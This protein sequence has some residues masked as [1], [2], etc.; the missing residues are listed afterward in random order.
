MK[1]SVNPCADVAHV[2]PVGTVEYFWLEN[3]DI[4][5]GWRQVGWAC[6]QLD[7]TPSDPNVVDNPYCPEAARLV[8]IER[9]E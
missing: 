6:L 4:P 1:L 3:G 8:I 2:A 7:F 5:K 9:I